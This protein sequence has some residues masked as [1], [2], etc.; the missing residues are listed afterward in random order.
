MCLHEVKEL[1]NP[2]LGVHSRGGLLSGNVGQCHQYGGVD[3]TDIIEE[4]S[5][6]LVYALLTSGVQERTV[7]GRCRSLTVFTIQDGIGRVGTMLWFER[8]GTG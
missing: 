2:F 8:R 7:I 1:V 4:T 5:N 3:G 6:N